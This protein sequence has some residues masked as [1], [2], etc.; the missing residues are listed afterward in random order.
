MLLYFNFKL[1]DKSPYFM[2]KKSG[3][4]IHSKDPFKTIFNCRNTAFI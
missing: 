4:L 2:L 1:I 3:I